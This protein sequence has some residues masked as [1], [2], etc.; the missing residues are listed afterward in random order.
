MTALGDAYRLAG[1]YAE[2]KT[3]LEKA[4]ALDATLAAPHY[5]L[6]L[7]FLYAGDKAGLGN[8]ERYAS[9]QREMEAYVGIRGPKAPP[10]VDDDAD[11]L[12]AT[13]KQKLAEVTSK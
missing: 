8:E 3:T 4:V 9:A 5:N 2:A 12:L 6:A 13:A 10:G 1:R 7:L 11:S